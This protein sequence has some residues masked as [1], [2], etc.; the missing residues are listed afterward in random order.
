MNRSKYK[1]SYYRVLNHDFSEIAYTKVGYPI[2]INGYV[3]FIG[4]IRHGETTGW[5]ATCRITGTWVGKRGLPS[6]T[7]TVVKVVD[8]CRLY[9]EAHYLRITNRLLSDHPMLSCPELLAQRHSDYKPILEF[10]IWKPEDLG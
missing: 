4:Y 1:V 3:F 2:S 6:F 5:Q 7:E 9:D 8:T 10:D